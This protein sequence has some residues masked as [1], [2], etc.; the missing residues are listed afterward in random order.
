MAPRLV[1]MISGGGTNLQAIIDAI[2]ENTLHAEIALVVSNRSKAYGLERAAKNNI[3]TL[4]KLLKPYKDQGKSR[5][6]YDV[7][8]GNEIIAAI[9]GKPS[10]I[11]LAGFMHILSPE[12]LQCFAPDS[13]IN[14]HP[15]L[16]GC[17]DGAKAIERAYEAFQKDEIKHTGVMVHYCIPEVDRG[18]VI[19]EQKCEIKKEDKLED[20]EARIHAIEHQ[21]IVQGT[22]LAL[23][24]AHPQ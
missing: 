2:A 10:L 9:G 12:F 11:V 21:L 17:F 24:L 5:V 15:A 4:V 7:D 8:L 19:L 22:S 6:D 20:L 3:P 14:L 1:V 16:P 23:M 18:K 13:V